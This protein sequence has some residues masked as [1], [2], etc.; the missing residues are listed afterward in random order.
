[1]SSTVI[2]DLIKILEPVNKIIGIGCFLVTFVSV[3]ALFVYSRLKLDKSAIIQLIAYTL[4]M[5]LRG[6]DYVIKDLNRKTFGVFRVTASL[7]NMA[8]LYFMVFEMMYIRAII[9][10]ESA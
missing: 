7:L 3:T 1:M 8:L 4:G 5:F 6:I 10:S 2:D 9:V